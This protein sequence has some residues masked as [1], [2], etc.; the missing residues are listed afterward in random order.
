MRRL[1]TEKVIAFARKKK[2]FTTDEVARRFKGT[3]MQAAACI[4]I[5]KIKGIVERSNPSKTPQGV[6]RWN[7]TG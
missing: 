2:A 5:M 3:R 1:N 6:S 7:F 4:A